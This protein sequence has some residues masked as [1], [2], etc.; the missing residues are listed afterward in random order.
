MKTINNASTIYQNICT[1]YDQNIHT[2]PQISTSN[3]QA[4][5]HKS[6]GHPQDFKIPNPKLQ[7]SN[8]LIHPS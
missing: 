8:F 5:K 7:T 4:G 3:P 6:T 1:R 2:H